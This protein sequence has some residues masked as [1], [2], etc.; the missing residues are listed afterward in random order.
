M[1]EVKGVMPQANPHW[2]GY[3][4]AAGEHHAPAAA[5]SGG[6]S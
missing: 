5:A 2:E 3:G 1:S 6:H 4:H